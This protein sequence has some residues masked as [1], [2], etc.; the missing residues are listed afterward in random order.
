MNPFL[1]IIKPPDFYSLISIVALSI[2]FYIY[3]RDEIDDIFKIGDILTQ[4]HPEVLGEFLW[5]LIICVILEKLLVGYKSE[6]PYKILEKAAIGAL[7]PVIANIVMVKLMESFHLG[8]TKG[9]LIISFLTF[10][11]IMIL[12]ITPLPFLS[13]IAVEVFKKMFLSAVFL[14]IFSSLTPPAIVKIVVAITICIV[15]VCFLLRTFR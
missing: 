3:I 9:L 14:A 12:G 8:G 11:G 1:K 13:D 2:S 10:A 4:K 15:G 7:S 5:S 6:F